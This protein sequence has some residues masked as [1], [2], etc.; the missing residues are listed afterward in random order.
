MKRTSWFIENYGA[1]TF[2]SAAMIGFAIA[3]IY[4][5]VTYGYHNPIAS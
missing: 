5:M 3:I 4:N 2:A 1:V